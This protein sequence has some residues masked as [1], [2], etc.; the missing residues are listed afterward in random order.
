MTSDVFVGRGSVTRSGD[1]QGMAT[2][3]RYLVC[4]EAQALVSC[5]S[6]ADVATDERWSFSDME[7]RFDVLTE[8]CFP[9]QGV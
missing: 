1:G 6:I 9:R 5:T 4:C 2:L 3:G 8:R 7:P